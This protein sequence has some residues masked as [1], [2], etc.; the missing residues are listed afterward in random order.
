MSIEVTCPKGHLFKVKDK[1]A[2]KKGLCPH[3]KEPVVVVVPESLSE[4]AILDIIG[5]APEIEA[6]PS[7]SVLEDDEPDSA[8]VLDDDADYGSTM[9]LVGTSAIRHRRDCPKCRAPIPYWFAKCPACDTYLEEY[10]A[11][12]KGPEKSE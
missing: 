11:S 1:Y 7:A 9:S 5:P 2:G 6:T 12:G 8:S 3:C 4:D 10:D